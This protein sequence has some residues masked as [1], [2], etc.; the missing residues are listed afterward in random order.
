MDTVVLMGEPRRAETWRKPRQPV[1]LVWWFDRLVFCVF[2]DTH[3][4]LRTAAFKCSKGIVP[5]E[6]LGSV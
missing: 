3:V 2:K 5:G 6:S 4:I 1:F